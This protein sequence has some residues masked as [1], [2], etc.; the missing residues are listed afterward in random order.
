[1]RGRAATGTDSGS[2]G[3][4][5]GGRVGDLYGRRRLFAIG[6][7][8]FT[9][10]S[11]ACGWAPTALLIVARVAQGTGAT[12]LVPRVL[13][14]VGVVPV[15]QAAAPE[16]AASF[17][18][19]PHR[20]PVQL[21]GTVA[22]MSRGAAVQEFSKLSASAGVRPQRSR[23]EIKNASTCSVSLRCSASSCVVNSAR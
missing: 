13:G 11:A 8:A 2:A 6:L 16:A 14:I 20:R 9:L 21:I 10:A 5:T 1:M 19:R 3:L 22:S 15:R 18:L 7:A 4:I 23:T 12:L 17:P